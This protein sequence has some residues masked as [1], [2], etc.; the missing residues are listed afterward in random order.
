[1]ILKKLVGDRAFYKRVLA[2]AIPIIIQNGLTNFVNLLD[3][4]MVG[5]LGTEAMSGV[6]IVNQFVFIFNLLIFGA[7]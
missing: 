1:M 5:A 7:V 2:V 4:V 3:N 6:S